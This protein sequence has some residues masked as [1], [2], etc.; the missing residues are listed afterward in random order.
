MKD[1]EKGSL[2]KPVPVKRRRHLVKG[3]GVE[4]FRYKALEMFISFDP[5]F[6][7]FKKYLVGVAMLRSDGITFKE[8]T[9]LLRQCGP[10]LTESE[11]RE[12]YRVA[13][14]NENVSRQIEIWKR[15]FSEI[16][17]ETDGIE[18]SLIAGK[19]T[20]ILKKNLDR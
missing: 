14:G 4:R 12:F 7:K 16:K 9:V 13:E 3:T 2:N 19:V 20:S 11:V 6:D 8:I 18:L 5:H 1:G 10:K 15:T 17:K